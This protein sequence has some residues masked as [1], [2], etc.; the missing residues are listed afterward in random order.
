MTFVHISTPHRYISEPRTEILP[1]SLSLPSFVSDEDTDI[2]KAIK[3]LPS[4]RV[5]IHLLR[6][7]RM[8][9]YFERYA[10]CLRGS[11]VRATNGYGETDD[12]RGR[13][14]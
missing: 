14:R 9:D 10:E 12:G 7:G 6:S 1:T 2:D 8:V 4:G 3:A 11:F 13:C 5:R